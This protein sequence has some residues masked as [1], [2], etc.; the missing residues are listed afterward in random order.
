MKLVTCVCAVFL[1]ATAVAA[2]W[3]PNTI[4]RPCP[5]TSTTAKVQV[6][7]DGD[8]GITPCSG[9][10]TTIGSNITLGTGQAGVTTTSSSTISSIGDVNSNANA[11]MLRINDST[12]S[13]IFNNDGS[14]AAT[15]DFQEVSTF[16]IQRTITAGGTTGN[17]TINKT[18]G[19]VN[20]AA[21]ATAI[22]VT[23]S[24]VNTSSL[25][26]TTIRTADATCTFVKSTVPAAGS[27]VITLNAGCTAETSVG[28][29][30]LN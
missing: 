26:F 14:A 30:V 8:V 23:N 19:T 6:E 18:A 28:F 4:Q 10:T 15:V 11:T 9:R 12:Q 2:Q 25:I 13:F 3:R 20:F 7:S 27:F 22:T 24:L 17:R 5:N 21:A 29:L 1:F 16:N